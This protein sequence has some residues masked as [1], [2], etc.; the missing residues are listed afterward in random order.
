MLLSSRTSY[1][2]STQVNAYEDPATR[3]ALYCLMT[4]SG[5]KKE[6]QRQ[7][8][9]NASCLSGTLRSRIDSE[10]CNQAIVYTKPDASG[11]QV[12]MAP[13]PAFR[14]TK[15]EVSTHQ[16][17]CGLSISTLMQIKF[18][19]TAEYLMFK[20]AAKGSMVLST[21]I[22][23]LDPTVR[24]GRI[25]NVL[26]SGDNTH[27][28]PYNIV[29]AVVTP[30][31]K[32]KGSRLLKMDVSGS[33][34]ATWSGAFKVSQKR[35]CKVTTWSDHFVTTQRIDRACNLPHTIDQTVHKIDPPKTEPKKSEGQETE[36]K[37][38]V[39]PKQSPP[40]KAPNNGSV[41][42]PRQEPGGK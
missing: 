7:L 13:R 34:K 27:E 22:E 37:T 16:P 6:I 32:Y 23:Y 21:D 38:T 39:P 14:C 3:D 5:A 9:I 40:P 25:E 30:T 1:A 33:A 17:K 29:S 26:I 35:E 28:G 8:S 36:K 4:S 24:K 31:F 41:K 19:A 2:Q 11:N 42:K 10:P 20:L 15:C 12:A 18:D